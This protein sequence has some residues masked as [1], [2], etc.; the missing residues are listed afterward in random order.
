MNGFKN[1]TNFIARIIGKM[2][3]R[4]NFYEKDGL[5][6]F[7]GAQFANNQHQVEINTRSG[8][9]VKTKGIISQKDLIYVFSATGVDECAKNPY[10]M[11]RA[12]E[13]RARFAGGL[14]GGHDVLAS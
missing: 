10:L 2:A 3:L 13:L 7:M 12:V 4:D 5:K 14:R 6:Q 8:H 11:L 1:Y 9:V